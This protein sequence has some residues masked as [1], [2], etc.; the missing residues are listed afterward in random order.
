MA[1]EPI[2][3]IEDQD[4]LVACPRRGEIDVQWC[5]GCPR[6]L[7]I[8]YDYDRAVVRCDPGPGHHDRHADALRDV[9]EPFR[10]F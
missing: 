3:L 1:V 8:S 9:P 7:V 6:R 2:E 10:I 5:L 4:G